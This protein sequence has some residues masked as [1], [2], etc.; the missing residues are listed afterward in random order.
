[1]FS[2]SVT[3]GLP[4]RSS[5]LVGKENMTADETKYGRTQSVCHGYLI[6]YAFY[7]IQCGI[8]VLMLQLPQYLHI[9]VDVYAEDE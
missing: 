7:T 8:F 5:K 9:S 3:A 1:V 2:Y 6:L 4:E